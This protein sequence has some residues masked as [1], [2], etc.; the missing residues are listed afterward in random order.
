MHT[1]HVT[2]FKRLRLLLYVAENDTK[3]KERELYHFK[4]VEKPSTL[5][6]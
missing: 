2:I 6:I 3:G 5:C 1:L 4:T